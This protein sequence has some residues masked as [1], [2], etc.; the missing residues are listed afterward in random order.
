MIQ[1]IAEDYYRLEETMQAFAGDCPSGNPYVHDEYNLATSLKDA[2][3]NRDF[4]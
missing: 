1:I 2:I 4:N 3:S